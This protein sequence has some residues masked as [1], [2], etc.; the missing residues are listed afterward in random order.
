[1]LGVVDSIDG[2]G[3]RGPTEPG[4]SYRCGSAGKLSEIGEPALGGPHGFQRVERRHA[5][6]SLV[7]IETGI[8]ETDPAL[9][10]AGRKCQR[11]TLTFEPA[12]VRHKAAANLLAQD[13]K[14]DRLLDDSARKH[15][16]GEARLEYGFEAQPLASLNWANEDPPIA[17][18]R[19]WH[20]HFQQTA[21][22][23]D[24]NFTERDRTDGRHRCQLGQYREYPVGLLERSRREL[25]QLV[26]PLPPLGRGRQTV[27]QIDQRNGVASEGGQVIERSPQCRRLHLFFLAKLGEPEPEIVGEPAD[28]TSPAITSSDY[29]RLD[30]KALP[31]PRRS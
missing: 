2:I 25:A 13:I 11:E 7:E 5:R 4:C 30:E 27:E 20:G 15:P 18:R 19:R 12:L 16:F 17:L 14:Q 29:R 24:E 26:E 6:P 8:G 23:D 22:E 31:A 21:F 3:R 9:G 1:M 28:P 10:C